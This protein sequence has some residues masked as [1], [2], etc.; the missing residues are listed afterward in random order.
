ME[1][2]ERLK[3]LRLE[4]KLTQTQVSKELGISQPAYSEWEKGTK[5]P[6]PDKLPKLA[7]YFGVSTDYL[8]GKD[9]VDLSE[10]ELLFRTISEGLSKDD[11]ETLKQEL[12]DF[13]KE[14][15]RAFNHDDK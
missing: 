1:L 14:R 6:T 12:V 2:S 11:R 15:S 4:K 8:L 7:A 3:S 10:V 5:S 13:M 9:D